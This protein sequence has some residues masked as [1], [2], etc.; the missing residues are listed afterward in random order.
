MFFT[1]M[2]GMAALLWELLYGTIMEFSE[3][4]SSAATDSVHFT[5]L[6]NLLPARVLAGGLGQNTTA[7]TRSASVGQKIECAPL[8]ATGT[9]N[10]RSGFRLLPAVGFELMAAAHLHQGK[11]GL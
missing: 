9:I 6:I 1:V 11:L 7:R 5:L 8:I 4:L 2:V 3:R 10:P